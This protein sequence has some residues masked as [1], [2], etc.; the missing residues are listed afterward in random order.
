MAR[1]LDFPKLSPD[2]ATRG[3]VLM[4]QG[5]NADVGK[6]LVVAGLC[7]AFTNRG[8]IVRPFKAQNMS[9]NAAV[10]VDSDV[11]DHAGE[12]GR[13]QALQAMACGSSFSVHMNPVLLKPESDDCSQVVLRGRVIGQISAA[14]YQNIKPQLLPAV[15]DSLR[16]LAS[17]ADLV[18]VEGAG[19]SAETYL[20]PQDITNMGLAE[21]ADLPVVLMGEDARGGMLASVVGSHALWS[22]A[23]RRRIKAYLVNRFRGDPK[24]FAPAMHLMSQITGWPCLGLISWFDAAAQL[25]QEDSLALDRPRSGRSAKLNIAVPRLPRVAN[26]DD[27]DPLAAEPEVNLFWLP[28]GTPVPADTDVVILP[29]SKATREDLK[30]LYTEG[31]HHDIR[32]HVRRGGVVVGLC[33]GFQMLGNAVHDP[34]GLEGSP[35][36]TQGL[37]L[38]NMET[39]ID[40]SKTLRTL[41]HLDQHSKARIQGYEM[42]MGVSKGPALS[43]PWLNLQTQDTVDAEGACGFDGR[44]FGSYVHGLFHND[45][46]RAH[47]LDTLGVKASGIAHQQRMEN[48]LDQLAAQLEADL[49]LDHLLSLA[50]KPFGG[51]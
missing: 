21:A 34:D 24:V 4:L 1:T 27:L 35:G 11:P 43:S 9:N 20:R 42:H 8:L 50:E 23:D 16:R 46:F 25:P 30:T 38:L 31:W 10:T 22:E 32:A 51:R 48:T 13:A 15:L 36:S 12:I 49:D 5:T 40:V 29:G 28:S 7:R 6:S 47:W 39:H 17:E 41:D 33:A 45:A 37:G 19:S 44:V 2:R 18:L 3:K 14:D 26:F